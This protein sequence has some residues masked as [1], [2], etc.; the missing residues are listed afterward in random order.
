MYGLGNDYH[1][2]LTSISTHSY[3]YVL[4]LDGFC[5]KACNWI[6]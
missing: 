1:N 2:K 6:F 3:K 4:F 5:M